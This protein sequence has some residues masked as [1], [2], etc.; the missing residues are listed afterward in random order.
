MGTINTVVGTD[1]D[2]Y[3]LRDETV[4]N[5]DTDVLEPQNTWAERRYKFDLILSRVLDY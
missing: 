2:N 3:I 1:P 4:H 5:F